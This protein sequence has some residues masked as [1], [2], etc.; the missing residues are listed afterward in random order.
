MEAKCSILEMLSLDA[1]QS[2]G[3]RAGVAFRENGRKKW[4]TVS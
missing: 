3:E 1:H 2:W 4:D